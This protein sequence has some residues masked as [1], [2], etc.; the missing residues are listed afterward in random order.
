MTSD[1]LC[2]LSATDLAA[3]IRRRKVS[4]VEVVDA[5]LD[6]IERL[7]PQI[8]A[9][10]T[11]TAD[12]AR[13]AARAAE[14]ALGQRRPA[15]GAAP[16]GA[17]LRQGPRH[18]EGRAD[19]VRHPS[20][21]RQ[22][23][24]RGRADGRPPEGGRRHHGRQDQHAD[25]RLAGR[26][27]QPALR[28]DPEPVAPGSHPGRL[29]RRRLGRGRGRPRPDRRR[30]RRGRL[31]PDPGLVRGDL[32]PQAL[33]RPDPDVSGERGVEPLPHRSDDADGGRRRPGHAGL[34]GARRARPVLA[35]G[36]AR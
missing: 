2:W 34:R 10:V 21:R 35:P 13:R 16:R 9:Y 32:R 22:R 27:P 7:N 6:R 31:D 17:V 33:L 5:V 18:H 11:V 12:E 29:E 20:L 19:D 14:R 15:L 28:G 1:E 36:R 30:D 24:D 3:L 26:D 25:D 8:N 4:P 23:A